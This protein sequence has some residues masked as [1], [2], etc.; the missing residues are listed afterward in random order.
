MRIPSAVPY[1]DLPALTAAAAAAGE[2][3]PDTVVACCVPGGTGDDVPGQAFEVAA[4]ALG[5]VQGWLA[6]PAVAASRLMLVTCRAVDAGPGTPV[7]VPGASVQGLVRAAVAENPGRFVL[8]DVDEVAG[9]GEF[10]VAGAALGEPEFAVRGGQLLVPRLARAS[11]GPAIS[12]PPGGTVLVTGAS[13]ALGGLVA[14]HLAATWGVRELVLLSR[15]GP[16]AAGL[17]GLVAE[18]AGLG[19]VARVAACDVAD[20]DALAAVIAALPRLSAVVHA[21]G[22]LD[23]GVIGSLTPARL[24]PVMRAKAAGAWH[25]H[26][27]TQVRD[28][29]AFVLFSSAAGIMGSAGQG[30]YA[31]ANTF[32]DA[33]AAHRRQQGLAGTS[34]AWGAWAQASGMAGQLSETDRQRMARAGLGALTEAEGLALLDAA[35]TADPALLVPARLDLG[36]LRD[37]GE[38]L[39]PVLSG[40]VRPARR[41]VGDAPV[42]GTGGLAARL[43]GLPVAEQDAAVE[44]IV[45]SQ[46]AQ[47]LGMTGP[48]AVNATR[49]FRDLG[50]DSLT[51]V[52]LRNQLAALCGL[53][54][55]ATLVFSY[56]TPAA[57][58]GYLRSRTAPEE[59]GQSA[60]KELDRLETL[61]PGM[62]SERDQRLKIAARLEALAR[63]IRAG[64]A[65]ETAAA[66]AELDLATDDE[67]FDLIDQELGLSR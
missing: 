34:L 9:A 3:V 15:S 62:D 33:L 23:D 22:V 51:A 39:P 52:E 27:L 6:E 12:S 67:M 55:P 60:L 31:A 48:E 59:D 30:S 45:L 19:A 42:A 54:L 35:A 37:R 18:L 66:T 14:R 28:L 63:H 20:R 4:A 21:A 16:D 36:R 41:A 10:L 24:E 53:Q 58:A 11:A 43:A 40:L 50:F 13:G 1:H 65:D 56:P 17:A 61:L 7:E 32:L 26:E 29:D 5:L 64:S 46:V 49:P 47:V 2:P 8:A 57:L 44:R 25:L 38:Q